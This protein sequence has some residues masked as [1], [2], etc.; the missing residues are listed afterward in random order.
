[1]ERA[2]RQ[3]DALAVYLKVGFAVYD[4]KIE[5][6]PYPEDFFRESNPGNG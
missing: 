5:M 2:G 3:P 6:Q 1:M 4:E